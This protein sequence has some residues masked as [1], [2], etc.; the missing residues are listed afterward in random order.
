MSA[1]LII[2]PAPI[3]TLAVSRGTGG[4][5]LLTRDPK[6]VWADDAVGSAATIDI[7]LGAV[8]SIDT[9]FL[10]YA[11]PAAV[12]A[13][14]T[15]TGGAASYT[16][17][18]I[19]ASGP[20]RAMD[21]TGQAPPISHAFWH[22]AAVSVRYLRLSVTQPAGSAALTIGVALAGLAF[23]PG[24]NKE[25]GAGRRPIDLGTATPLQ[26]GGFSIVEG[27][28]KRYYGWTLGDLTDDEVE[29]LDALALEVGNTSPVLVVED[30]AATTALRNRIHYGLLERWRQYERR[31]RGRTKWEFGIEEWV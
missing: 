15:I 14:W 9:L 1:I 7:D 30:P 11:Q 17:T 2:A 18:V 19:K 29:T 26:S 16:A 25:W 13:I 22:G 27:A 4:A 23:V 21:A 28:R 6:E 10:G 31:S 5:N 8:R 24:L 20:L 12:A 3:A